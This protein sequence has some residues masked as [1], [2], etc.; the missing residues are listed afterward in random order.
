MRSWLAKLFK[1]I[2]GDL[3][4]YYGPIC[5]IVPFAVIFAFFIPDYAIQLTAILAL[6]VYYFFI[7]YSKWF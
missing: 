2:A 7:K 3:F 5:I 6:I 4:F 1:Q